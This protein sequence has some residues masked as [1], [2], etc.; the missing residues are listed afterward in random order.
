MRTQQSVVLHLSQI[1]LPDVTFG[2]EFQVVSGFRGHR[3]CDYALYRLYQNEK[4]DELGIILFD[5]GILLSL[6]RTYGT[7]ADV[8]LRERFHLPPLRRSF[9]N[10]SIWIRTG[11][12]HLKSPV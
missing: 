4:R 2:G 8:H 9:L 12:M 7:P 10:I 1:S 11:T 5:E 6:V 3:D